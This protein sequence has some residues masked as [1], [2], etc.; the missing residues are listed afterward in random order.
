MSTYTQIC[1]H[2]VFSTKNRERT[3]SSKR[4]EDLYRYIWGII[5]N[6]ESHLYRVGGTEDHIHILTTLHPR[7]ALADLVKDIKVGSAH[8]IAE[9]RVF[10]RFTHWQE[11]YAAF[12]ASHA[13][14]ARLIE[15]IKRQPEHHKRISF[16]DELRNLL[17]EAGV[18][19]DERYLI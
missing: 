10:P 5:Q 19:F 8:W 14:K 6:H 2:L 12:T 17:V 15:Y 16:Q 13:E 18:E 3:L 4:R 9:S 11:G 1:Y 7:I